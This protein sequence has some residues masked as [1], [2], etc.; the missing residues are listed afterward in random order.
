MLYRDNSY[1]I[2]GSTLFLT[3]ELT[4]EHSIPEHIQVLVLLGIFECFEDDLGFRAI[5]RK[6]N[7]T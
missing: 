7:K 3:Q 6:G 5:W 2:C 4:E 1:V